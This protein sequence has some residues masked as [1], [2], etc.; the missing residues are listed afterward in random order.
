VRERATLKW[1]DL[2]CEGIGAIGN[3]VLA[4]GCS[5]EVLHSSKEGEYKIMVE[6]ITSLNDLSRSIMRLWR[7]PDNGE[8]N[9]RI[10]EIL[11]DCDLVVC[12][13]RELKDRGIA[14][15]VAKKPSLLVSEEWTDP[16]FL[17]KEALIF[18]G[19]EDVKKLVATVVER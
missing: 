13:M 2:V 19:T 8:A 6:N 17:G 5:V 18:S 12:G 16:E 3:N 10:F 11:A 14:F 9:S 7:P 1:Q 15:A 4:L